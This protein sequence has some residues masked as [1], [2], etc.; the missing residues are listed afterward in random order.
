[1]KILKTRPA[2]RDSEAIEPIRW[3]ASWVRP[4]PSLAALVGNAFGK[5]RVAMRARVLRRLLLPVGPLALMV[6]A[7][8]T[9]AKYIGQARWIRLSVSLDDA[10]SVTARQVVELARYVEQ[11]NPAILL[12]VLN[13]LSRDATTM[14]ALSASVAAVMVERLSRARRPTA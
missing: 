12:Q 9:F 13:V 5:A 7:G 14:A 4:T 3:D 11:S 6:I 1:M 8:G 10:A 2:S